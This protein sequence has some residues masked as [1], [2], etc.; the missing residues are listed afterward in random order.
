MIGNRIYPVGTQ[1]AKIYMVRSTNHFSP[2]NIISAHFVCGTS[3]LVKHKLKDWAAISS[4]EPTVYG[5]VV[6]MPV[7]HG[8]IRC[9][10]SC[11]EKIVKRQNAA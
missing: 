9:L 5:T 4:I 11:I 1:S 8:N 7:R 2:P 3:Y 6:A 10:V